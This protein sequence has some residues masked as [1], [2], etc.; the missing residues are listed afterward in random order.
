[1]R[2]MG[3]GAARLSRSPRLCGA[4]RRARSTLSSTRRRSGALRRA[5]PTLLHAGEFGVADQV[6]FEVG[7]EGAL[8]AEPGEGAFCLLAEGDLGRLRVR[9]R[10]RGRGLQFDFHKVGGSD[11]GGAGLCVHAAGG[12]EF[13]LDWARKDAEERE[14]VVVGNVPL[15]AGE[16]AREVAAGEGRHAT[17]VGL[18]EAALLGEA[19]EGDA[20]VAHGFFLRFYS[21]CMGFPAQR[22]LTV[23]RMGSMGHRVGQGAGLTSAGSRGGAGRLSLFVRSYEHLYSMQKGVNNFLR[24]L[25]ASMGTLGTNASENTRKGGVLRKYF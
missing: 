3:K 21:H 20:Q 15:L 12:D 18:I 25:F 11:V 24:F 17:Y 6:L 4:L 19:R 13:G 23:G 8:A 14:K 10:C 1:M 22:N 5:R 9:L 7:I 16:N 2:R